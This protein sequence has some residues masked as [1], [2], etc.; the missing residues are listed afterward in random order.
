MGNLRF[1]LLAVIVAGGGFYWFGNQQDVPFTGRSQFVTVGLDQASA[2]GE[3]AY[4]E[5][6]SQSDVV[7]RG[8]TAAMVER[9]GRKLADVAA[10]ENP[11]FEWQFTLVDS[12]QANAFALPGGYTAVYTGLLP[13]TVNEDGLAAV[14][15]HEMGHAIARHGSERMSQQQVVQVGAVAVGLLL[16]DQSI[17]LQRIAMQAFGLGAQYGF[18]LPFSRLHEEEADYIGLILTARACFDPREAPKIWERMSAAGNG[19]PPEFASTHPSHATRID[20]LNKWMPDALAVGEASC[21][22]EQ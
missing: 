11:G 5:I 10:P 19:Q 8:E 18:A 7:T 3:E 16:G 21:G 14:I 17:E 4:N 15:G 22:S 6:L 9:I 13:L 20:N 12:P 1:L 2:L